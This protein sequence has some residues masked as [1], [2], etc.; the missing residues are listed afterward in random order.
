MFHYGSCV[1]PRILSYPLRSV[2]RPEARFS[3]PVRETIMT[4][5][6][7]IGKLYTVS[8][9]GAPSTVVQ[10]VHAAANDLRR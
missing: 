10:I 1:Y 3:H 4:A 8:L 5:T 2:Q 6:T 7:L 9:S